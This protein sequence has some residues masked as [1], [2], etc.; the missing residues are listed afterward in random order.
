MPRQGQKIR[1]RPAL[2]FHVVFC[3]D[4]VFLPDMLPTKRA[5][6]ARLAS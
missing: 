6:V 1:V 5:V 4:V 2:V 3:A